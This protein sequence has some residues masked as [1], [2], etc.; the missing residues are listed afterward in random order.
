MKMLYMLRPSLSVPRLFNV[1]TVQM[2]PARI[3]A[4]TLQNT[5]HRMCG[6]DSEEERKTE[7]GVNRLGRETL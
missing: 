4:H 5:G 6:H 3:H 2:R 1:P 7:E